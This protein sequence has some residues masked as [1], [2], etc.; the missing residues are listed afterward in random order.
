LADAEKGAIG[1][2][3]TGRSRLE[4]LSFLLLLFSPLIVAVALPVLSALSWILLNGFRATNRKGQL[5]LGLLC[6][7]PSVCLW[8]IVLRFVYRLLR[9][10]VG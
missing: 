4:G 10:R 5:W 6:L 9:L 3:R 2:S 7:L 8:L 1:L